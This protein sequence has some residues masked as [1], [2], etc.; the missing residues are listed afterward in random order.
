[1]TFSIVAFDPKTKDLGIAVGSK[2]PA[3]GAVVPWARAGVGAVTTQGYANASYGP[4]GLALMKR[5]VTPKQA[6]RALTQRDREKGKRQVGVVDARG[7]TASF[8]GDGCPIWAGHLVGRHYAIQ[9]NI[10][11]G[12]PVVKAMAAAFESTEGDLP[13]RLLAALEAGQS[14]GGDR[15]GQQSAALLVVREKGGYGG[16]TDRW[17][18][19][20]VDD[21]RTPIRELRRVFE[22]YDVT[23]LTREDPADMVAITPE[24]AKWVQEFL[25]KRGR[26][27]GPI[28][29]EW[30][31]PTA[32]AFQD[33]LGIE[34]LEMKL[35]KDGKLWGSVWRYLLRK[36][37]EG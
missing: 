9:G 1:M 28:D 2:F 17:I 3:V 37:A 4:R 35:R 5:G 8:T 36:A 26:Y 24:V 19:L 33:Y 23:M 31:A 15:R 27:Q 22:V 11:A 34:N 13:S 12:E 32:N 14:A 25:A 29:G 7:R 6:I 21:H 16:Y 20:R 30:S 18:D 10:L